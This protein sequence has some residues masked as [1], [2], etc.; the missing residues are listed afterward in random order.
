MPK[1]TRAAKTTATRTPYVDALVR[2]M[3]F[4]EAGH[5]VVGHAL[6]WTVLSVSANADKGR[7]L[8]KGFHASAWG[9]PNKE[10][11]RAGWIADLRRE[12]TRA[13][14]GPM[15]SIRHQEEVK[16]RGYGC[17][18]EARAYLRSWAFSLLM[19]F[20]DPLPDQ[21][22]DFRQVRRGAELIYEVQVSSLRQRGDAE[23]AERLEKM[24]V[25]WDETGR[26]EEWADSILMRYWA[27]VTDI[28][29]A[30]HRSKSGCLHRRQLL[31]RLAPVTRQCS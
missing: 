12:M 5:I 2:S 29:A 15:A 6:G 14:A 21:S 22:D 17:A 27:V 23:G 8:F 25:H 7:A 11:E 10:S 3:C 20:H 28:A 31:P 24:R 18:A 1:Q 16:K 26:A 9:A 19:D 4:H 13:A 30:L